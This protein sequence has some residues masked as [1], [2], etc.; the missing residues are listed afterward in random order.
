VLKTF[1]SLHDISF[2]IID[3]GYICALS[4]DGFHIINFYGNNGPGG[5]IQGQ[6]REV[7]AALGGLEGLKLL[8]GDFNFISKHSERVHFASTR[9][10]PTSRG[11]AS[12]S[13]AGN[14]DEFPAETFAAAAVLK[15]SVLDPAGLSEVPFPHFTFTSSSHVSKLDRLYASLSPA[16]VLS[17][18]VIAGLIPCPPNALKNI[19]DGDEDSDDI[20]IPPRAMA[21]RKVKDGLLSDHKPIWIRV[22]NM[23]PSKPRPALPGWVARR[24]EFKFFAMRCMPRDLFVQATNPFVKLRLIVQAAIAGGKKLRRRV[25]CMPSSKADFL[26]IA[27]NVYGWLSDA[28]EAQRREPQLLRR[29]ASSITLVPNLSKAIRILVPT[30][31]SPSLCVPVGAAGNPGPWIEVD[32]GAL[33]LF[34]AQL[35]KD[36]VSIGLDETGSPYDGINEQAH[37]Q[38]RESLISRLKRLRPR[39]SN[40]VRYIVDAGEVISCPAECAKLLKKYWE[41]V[42]SPRI[43]NRAKMRRLLQRYVQANGRPFARYEWEITLDRVREGILRSKDSA[44]GPDGVPFI[45][46]RQLV[47]VAAPVLLECFAHVGAGGHVDTGYWNQQFGWFL[48]KTPTL[49]D[50]NVQAYRPQATRPLSGAHTI[51]RIYSNILR[52]LLEENAA[53]WL[54]SCHKG[55]LADRNIDEC[56]EWAFCAFY[57]DVARQDLSY[58]LFIDFKEAFPSISHEFIELVLISLGVPAVFVRQLMFLYQDVSHLAVFAATLFA[59]AAM[60][61]GV[62]QGDPASPIL[63]ILV[64]EILAWQLRLLGLSIRCF[65]DD[66]AL[67]IQS[68][69]ALQAVWEVFEEFRWISGM[70]VKPEKTYLVPSK[71]EAMWPLERSRLS[72]NGA[73]VLRELRILL[74]ISGCALV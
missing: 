26:N 7:A 47:D 52:Q 20:P 32:F 11:E 31:L 6:V 66:I 38:A 41:G 35:A 30:P 5:D 1:A 54:D 57:R 49:F 9:N 14:G 56:I 74:G 73:V 70:S 44:V 50:D 10:K 61:S 19:Q 42:W 28:S 3:R 51:I 53:P 34:T 27:G 22:I 29:V 16:E 64:V 63:L 21:H 62:K 72:P 55:F 39:P 8:T 33:R 46:W 67:R 15:E 2:S 4:V 13:G 23:T 18:H 65:A 59:G 68:L 40:S 17:K 60:R 24:P 25:T 37:Q 36:E 71:R 45:A 48:G 58:L 43:T 69:L 12:L